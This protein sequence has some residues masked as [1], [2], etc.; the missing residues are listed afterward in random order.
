[1]T[2]Q[3]SD[4]VSLFELNSKESSQFHSLRIITCSFI[5]FQLSTAAHC[6]FHFSSFTVFLMALPNKPLYTNLWFSVFVSREANLYQLALRVVL[7]SALWN[8]ILDLDRSAGHENFITL[9]DWSM[10]SCWHAIGGQSLKLSFFQSWWVG[11]GIGYWW[12]GMCQQVQYLK[13][14]E[15]WRKL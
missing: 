2:S 15:I 5:T 14:W 1:M 10:D 3:I 12:K 4:A 9:G 6:C 13:C 7:G 11:C 8:G